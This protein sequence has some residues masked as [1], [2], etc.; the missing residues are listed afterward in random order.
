[1]NRICLSFSLPIKTEDDGGPNGRPGTGAGKNRLPA[2]EVSMEE[3]N[4]LS[5]RLDS[6]ESSVG[7]VLSKVIFHRRLT[8]V[9]LLEIK[10]V[11]QQF[12]SIMSLQN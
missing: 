9:F 6:M 4:E 5:K 11:H 12:R 2:H 1:M 10:T 3:Y 7:F 8:K